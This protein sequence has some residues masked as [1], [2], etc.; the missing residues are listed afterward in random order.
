MILTRDHSGEF[1]LE[2]SMEAY[3]TDVTS[4]DTV[5][6]NDITLTAYQCKNDYSKILN[7]TEKPQGSTLTVCIVTD[8]ASSVSLIGVS[9][10]IS[11]SIT[12]SFA[13]TPIITSDSKNKSSSN[14]V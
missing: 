11:P 13:V 14:K 8:Q 4:L 9:M 3:T 2:L 6:G 7:P 12:N 10:N 1:R 5:T